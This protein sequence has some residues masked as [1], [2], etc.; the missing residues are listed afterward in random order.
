[1]AKSRKT[2]PRN[3]PKTQADVDAAWERGVM[4]GVHYASAMF[5]N[6]LLDKFNARDYVQ[7]IWKEMEKL[8]E[9][10][11]EKR[12]KIPEITRMLKEEY[13]IEL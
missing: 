7:D 4:D 13:D 8:S 1:M 9:E 6:V 3:I 5:M 12:V 2:N 10:V 11:L